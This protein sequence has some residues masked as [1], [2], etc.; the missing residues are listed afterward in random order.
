MTA[1]DAR[2]A[3][4]DPDKAL[5]R[6]P[7]R[8]RRGATRTDAWAGIPPRLAPPVPDVNDLADYRAVARRIGWRPMSWQARAVAT[9]T[10]RRRGRY[11]YPEAAV[12]V[13]RQNGKTALLQTLIILK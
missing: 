8:A 5:H 11:A 10:G 9:I 3:P 12:V 7:V 6:P 13:A 1:V 4:V 2:S